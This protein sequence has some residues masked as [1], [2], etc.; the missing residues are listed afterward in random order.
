MPPTEIGQLCA[1]DAHMHYEICVLQQR[2][3]VPCA[4]RR[5]DELL[6]CPD[7]YE[8]T[9]AELSADAGTETPTYTLP[10]YKYRP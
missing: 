8:T 6:S 3:W 2:G 4:Q 7:A 1:R 9:A 10:G 5:D